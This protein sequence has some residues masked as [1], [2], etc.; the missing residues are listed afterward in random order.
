[1]AKMLSLS[2]E[3]IIE[4]DVAEWVRKQGL[5][6]VWRHGAWHVK[7]GDKWMT[8]G[9][10]HPRQAIEACWESGELDGDALIEGMGK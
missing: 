1:M 2:G 4:N 3:V 10:E 6:V 8:V 7:Q 9:Y 5:S